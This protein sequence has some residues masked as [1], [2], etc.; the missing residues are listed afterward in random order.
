M[1][2]PPGQ[3]RRSQLLTSFGPG[4]MVDLPNCSVLV[5]GLEGWSAEG[6]E[7]T[8]PRLVD[9]LKA[10]FDPPLLNLRL[11]APP[12]DNNEPNAKPTGITCW[13]FPE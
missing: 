11:V 6:E 10:L 7:I 4:S 8:E 13:Q 9:K 12:P 1:T 5:G 3:I 2:R